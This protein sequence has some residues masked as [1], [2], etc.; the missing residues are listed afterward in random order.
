VLTSADLAS[1]LK[2]R[3]PADPRAPES[4]LAQSLARSVL[5][6]GP[7]GQWRRRPSLCHDGTAA[8]LSVKMSGADTSTDMVRLLV[9]PGSLR[10]TVAQQLSH[11]LT[12]LDD[13]LGLLDWRSAADDI[14]IITTSVLPADAEQTRG[15]WGGMWLGGEFAPTASVTAAHRP[16]AEL[17]I[18]LN[19]RH[20]DAEHRWRLVSRMFERFQQHGGAAVFSPWLSS[21]VRRTT[22]VG[23]GI[24]VMSGR[25][26]AVRLYVAVSAVDELAIPVGGLMDATA[27]DALRGAYSSFTRLF[28]PL[29]SGT[30]TV[31]VDFLRDRDGEFVDRVGRVKVE[32][33][34]QGVQHD[35]RAAVI[36][37]TTSVLADWTLDAGPLGRFVDDMDSSWGGFD[38]QHISLGFAPQPVH[39]TVYAKPS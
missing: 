27:S 26:A 29:P 34:C 30:V 17:R 7:T 21:T 10:M 6:S 25:V 2:S 39:V 9:E 3:L 18:Y 5:E 33:S 4:V 8:Q 19:L 22:P 37:W 23:L 1:Y 36:D 31:G 11:G 28:G 24:V 13:L 15:W 35:R 12:A 38:I 20:G 16:P 32:L 14:N